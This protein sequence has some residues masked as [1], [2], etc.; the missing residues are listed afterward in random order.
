MVQHGT[1]NYLKTFIMLIIL[2]RINFFD[3]SFVHVIGVT[4][5]L[6]VLWPVSII[7]VN[8]KIWQS[9]TL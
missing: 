9:V 8:V 2:L 5:I 7:Q 4:Y 1:I 3:V 6:S